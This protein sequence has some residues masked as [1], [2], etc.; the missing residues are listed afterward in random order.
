VY[1]YDVPDKNTV[2][3]AIQNELAR[4]D[5]LRAKAKHADLSDEPKELEAV[6]LGLAEAL[7]TYAP[8]GGE[9][10][11]TATRSLIDHGTLPHICVPTLASLLQDLK[12]ELER[13]DAN[14]ESIVEPPSPQVALLQNLLM[15]LARWRCPGVWGDVRHLKAKEHINAN[16][17]AARRLIQA[18][19]GT[20]DIGSPSIRG[21]GRH[22]S[23]ERPGDAF[24]VVFYS[25][26]E[27]GR[28]HPA[29]QLGDA[30]RRA[31]GWYSQLASG[32]PVARVATAASL[33]IESAI[34]RALRLAFQSGPPERERDVQ[35]AVEVILRSLAV[36][37]TREQESSAIGPRGFTPD[38][39]VSSEDLAIEVKLATPKHLAGP[40]QEEIA[41]DVSGYSVKWR[42]ALFVI[43]D[44]GVITDP[45]RMREENMRK[46]GVTLLIIKH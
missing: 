42:R 13:E 23:E 28:P 5:A 15:D 6:A 37:F 25:H 44:L 24:D 11:L 26:G 20:T 7:L 32:D 9:T 34:V 14:A 33:D 10:W 31:L 45:D 43:Y 40:I 19:G 1:R 35:N 2:L 30:I 8:R 41:A 18:A 22:A 39:V 36:V 17:F 29:Q 4:Y 27:M 12:A 3:A 16:A 38:F 21:R 46:F